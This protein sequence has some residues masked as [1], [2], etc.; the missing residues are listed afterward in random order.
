MKRF[1]GFEIRA[2]TNLI[3]REMHNDV[4]HGMDCNTSLHGL[5]IDF[6][7]TNK[8]RD[9]FQRDFEEE[10]SM[11]RSTASRMLKL[12]EEHGL[13]ERLA[14][15]EDARLKKIV[16]NPKAIKVHTSFKEVMTA[17]ENKMTKDISD[18]DL[19]IFYEV[20]DKIKKNLE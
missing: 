20:I 9:I 12:M 3:K 15:C 16:L 4:E 7:V 14:V 8:D 19:D 17:L 18:H 6:L 10:F 2:L 11:R 1:I 13:I 5:V